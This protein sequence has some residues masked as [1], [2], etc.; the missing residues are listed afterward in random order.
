MNTFIASVEIIDKNGNVDRV[1]FPV[2]D[3]AVQFWTYPGY[4]TLF[5]INL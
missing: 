5:Y 4:N 2:P 3:F 1:Y